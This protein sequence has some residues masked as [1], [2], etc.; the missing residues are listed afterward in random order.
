MYLHLVW[1]GCIDVLCILC[2]CVVV[3]K[4]CI[5]FVDVTCSTQYIENRCVVGGLVFSSEQVYWGL[6][7]NTC[8]C[9]GVEVL[10]EFRLLHVLCNI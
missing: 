10:H 1:N 4:C 3:L 7:Y 9:C 2:V 5:N 6:A 8:M